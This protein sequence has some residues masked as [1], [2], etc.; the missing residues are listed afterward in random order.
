MPNCPLPPSPPAF[1]AV[2]NCSPGSAPSL[3][4][5]DRTPGGLPRRIPPPTTTSTS[6]S[7]S[8]PNVPQDHMPE[9]PRPARRARPSALYLSQVAEHPPAAPSGCRV[10]PCGFIQMSRHHPAEDLCLRHT[11][12]A[13]ERGAGARVRH[14]LF[15]HLICSCPPS[16]TSHPGP[17]KAEEHIGV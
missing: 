8:S 9:C 16:H 4:A 14:T 17:L 13:E 2:T 7:N 1:L 12:A 5:G 15:P 3:P 6:T 10:G 11:A